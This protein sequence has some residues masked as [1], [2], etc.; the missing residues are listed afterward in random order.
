LPNILGPVIVLAT[1]NVA[2]MILSESFLSYLGLGVEPPMP[3]WGKML[4][5][6]QPFYRIAPWLIFSPGLMIL[7]TVLGFNLLG[8][9]LRDV[10]D[11]KSNKE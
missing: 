5:D 10:L 9:G 8:E 6:G 7:L 3:S 2:A 4:A 11:P 1:L